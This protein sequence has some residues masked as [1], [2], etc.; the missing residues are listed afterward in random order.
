VSR[1]RDRATRLDPLPPDA[2]VQQAFFDMLRHARVAQK[3]AQHTLAERLGL[4]QRQ[5]SDLER[6]AMDPRLSTVQ[7]V[8]RALDL[9]VMLV[10]RTLIGVVERLRQAV[11]TLPGTPPEGDRPRYACAGTCDDGDPA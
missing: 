5:I 1:P 2:D 9:E 11:S 8:A 4:R 6:A 7:D 3:L 10:P